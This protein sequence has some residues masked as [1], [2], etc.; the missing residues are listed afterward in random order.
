MDDDI[1]EKPVCNTLYRQSSIEI[2]LSPAHLSDGDISDD[3]DNENE[4]PKIVDVKF[5]KSQDCSDEK[6]E[7]KK[8]LETKLVLELNKNSG[9]T[10]LLNKKS[11]VKTSQDSASKKDEIKKNTDSK[12]I[13]SNSETNL[14][15]E[16]KNKIGK[17]DLSNENSVVKTSE[18]SAD[19]ADKITKNDDNKKIHSNSRTKILKSK[20][21]NTDLSNENNVFKK[22]QEDDGNLQWNS[23]INSSVNI[24][25][26]QEFSAGILK[27]K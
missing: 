4:K 10:N 21:D 15:L 9:K 2:R 1:I 26:K 17:S 24:F 25:D 7:F 18:H 20:N 6:G 12:K 23:E 11:V 13:L 16:L 8:N 22:N 19:K 27:G 14:L 5:K 3:N